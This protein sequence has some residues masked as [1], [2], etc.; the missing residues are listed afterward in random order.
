MAEEALR[1][2]EQANNHDQQKLLLRIAAQWM[3][4]ADHVVACVRLTEKSDTA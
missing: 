4:L 3:K 1:S 2:A